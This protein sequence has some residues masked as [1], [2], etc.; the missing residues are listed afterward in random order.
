M[1]VA[2]PLAFPDYLIAVETPQAVVQVPDLLPF[3]DI[4]PER[5]IIKEQKAKVPYLGHAGVLF[6]DGKSGLSKY[7]EY[8]R[9]DRA[10]VGLVRRVR[11]PDT[12]PGDNAALAKVLNAISHKSGQGGAIT[13]A[14]LELSD[15]AFEKMLAYA[16]KREKENH[17]P[18][19]KAYDITSYSCLHFAVAVCEAGGAKLPPVVDPRPTGH[20]ALIRM[21][22]RDLDFSA[23]NK[24]EIDAT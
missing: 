4:L 21:W 20:L 16:E 17:N 23:P 12:T 24:L 18:R 1:D 6:F 3:I 9:Y 8:G 2:I 15:G 10:A 11:I 7:Y 22:H 5:I 14:Y 19:R 13:G